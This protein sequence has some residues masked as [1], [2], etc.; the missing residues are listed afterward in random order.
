MRRREFITLVVGGTAALPLTARAQQAVLPTVGMLLSGTAEESK[1][2][3]DAFRQGLSETRHVEGRDV[4]IEYR[5]AANHYDRLPELAAEL[6]RRPV[7]VLFAAGG[8]GVAPH[9]AKAS[10]SAIP[11]VFAGG[12]DPVQAGLVASLN[13]PGGN[14]TGVTFLTN[15]LEAKRLGLLHEMLPHARLIAVIV[16]PDNASVERAIEDLTEAARSLSLALRIARANNI[17][18]FEPAFA[19]FVHAG[20]DGLIVASD[21]F[22]NNQAATLVAL[23][24]RYKLPAIHSFPA[25]P[26]AGGLASYGTSLTDAFRLCGSYVGRILNGEKPGDLPVVQ[27]TKFGFVLNLKTANA[28]GLTI[29]PGLLAIADEVIE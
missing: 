2:L 24:S 11:I 22:L 14:V 8:G 27:S 23:A 20:A 28:L 18:D 10:T 17:S 3:V 9:A 6:V 5:Y 16:N 7:A 26:E 13:R 15:S 12:F 19:D 25:F 29:P 1:T 4:A 21:A